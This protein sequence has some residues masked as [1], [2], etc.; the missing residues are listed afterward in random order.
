MCSFG[1]EK[2]LRF[3]EGTSAPRDE[4]STFKPKLLPS[5]HHFCPGCGCY[6]FWTGMGM[7]GTNLRM[8]DGIEV[9]K[10]DRVYIDGKSL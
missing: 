9:E 2:T 8:I 10:L 4:L 5:T 1:P 6:L 3:D 7:V